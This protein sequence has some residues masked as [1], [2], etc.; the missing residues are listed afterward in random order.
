VTSKGCLSTYKNTRTKI[1][2]IVTS[3][4]LLAGML[5]VPAKQI[6]RA[7]A[8]ANVS[9]TQPH[10]SMDQ[11]GNQIAQMIAK[12]NPGANTLGISKI[13]V[14]TYTQTMAASSQA[15]ASDAITE[16]NAY[17]SKFTTGHVPQALVYLGK[18]VAANNLQPVSQVEAAIAQQV[19]AGGSAA[20]VL[21]QRTVEIAAGTTTV[22]PQ[23]S[24]IA[25]NVSAATGG[26]Q[27]PILQL[28]QQI[29]LQTASS[30]GGTIQVQKFVTNI[31]NSVAKNPKHTS[32][33]INDITKN[34]F[35][36]RGNC[37]I[38]NIPNKNI[39][40]DSVCL[41]ELVNNGRLGNVVEVSDP[42]LCKNGADCVVNLPSQT[43]G[44]GVDTIAGTA[45]KTTAAISKQQQQPSSG[46]KTTTG[47]PNKADRTESAFG[48]PMS[49]QHPDRK[50]LIGDDP[51]GSPSGVG[52]IKGYA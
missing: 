37:I 45:S 48:G 26:S 34:T 43:S 17:A 7:Y 38:N 49:E 13:L 41:R 22:N 52:G 18:L 21:V 19:R 25:Q 4:I 11:V 40:S 32:Q 39:C 50:R 1:V 28:L 12:Y 10:G 5:F 6:E 30:G 29:V 46:P 35:T 31:K 42:K 23:L 33:I 15:K 27:I 20:E 47:S 2:V 9:I 8:Q 51:A 16:I 24:L 14:D 44:K 3:V 36:C